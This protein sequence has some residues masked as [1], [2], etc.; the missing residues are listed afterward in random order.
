MCIL[1]TWL[2]VSK[3]KWYFAKGQ[4]LTIWTEK[5]EDLLIVLFCVFNV[6]VSEIDEENVKKT[7]KK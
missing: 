3:R 4:T 1:C 5:R 2:K 6:C 7:I